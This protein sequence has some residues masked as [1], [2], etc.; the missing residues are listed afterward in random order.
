MVVE[1]E[2]YF[3]YYPLTLMLHIND[4]PSHVFELV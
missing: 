3:G 2:E 1:T 4:Y